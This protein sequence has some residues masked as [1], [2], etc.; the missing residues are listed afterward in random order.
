MS[1]GNRT[2]LATLDALDVLRLLRRIR[3]RPMVCVERPL[4]SAGVGGTDM[5]I[6]DVGKGATI[7][8]STGHMPAATGL[9]ALERP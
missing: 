5:P 9:S 8:A 7:A 4:A 2:G 6:D 1:A 3:H